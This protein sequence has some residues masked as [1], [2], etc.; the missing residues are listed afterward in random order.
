MTGS[1]ARIPVAGLAGAG[2]LG[3]GLTIVQAWPLAIVIT[4][5][6]IDKATLSVT[7][8]GA[9]V[10]VR[11]RSHLTPAADMSQAARTAGGRRA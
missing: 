9:A 5:V 2:V 8:L 3:A 6:F 1:G 10:H 7:A 11:R 4:Q